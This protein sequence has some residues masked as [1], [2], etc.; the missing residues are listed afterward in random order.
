MYIY[1]SYIV[2]FFLELKSVYAEVVEKKH[3]FLFRKMCPLWN[4]VKKYCRAGQAADE[5][6]ALAHFLLYN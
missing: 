4:D 6:M 2:Q 1:V 3:T 5:G